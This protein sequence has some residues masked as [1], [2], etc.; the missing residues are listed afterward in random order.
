MSSLPTRP[1]RAFRRLLSSTM[2]LPRPVLRVVAGAPDTNDRGDPLDP[3]TQLLLRL[4]ALRPLDL[5]KASPRSARRNLISSIRIVEGPVRPVARVEHHALGDGVGG[6]RVYVPPGP[7]PHP[8]LVFAH[9]GGWVIGDLRSHDRWCRRLCVDGAQVVVALDYPLAP[10]HP[11]PEGLRGVVDGLRWVRAHARWFDGDPAR[12]AI[13]GDSAGGNLSAAACLAL[14]DGGEPQPAFQLLVY[15][16]GDLRC[17]SGSY[18]ALGHGYLLTQESIRWY[19]RHYG[20]DPLDVR[21]SVLLEP[22]FAGLAPAIVVTAG[23]DPLR[24]DGEALVAKLTDAGVRVEHLPFPSLIHGFV[25]MDGALPAA[26]RA[27]ARIVDQVR[28][29]WA[30]A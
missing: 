4:T 24:D 14:R 15:P 25:N 3:D 8:V 12:I 30:G 11:Y 6:C 7:G 17:L 9:G 18:H 21:A 13:G 20:A 26:D 5:E 27:A 16:A 1:E 29:W 22:S 19:L 2:R 28:A 10:E 23:F